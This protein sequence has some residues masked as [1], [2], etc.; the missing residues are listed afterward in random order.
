M[1]ID[2]QQIELLNKKAQQLNA[3]RQKLLGMQQSAREAF[4]KAVLLYKKKYGVD[5]DD[6][7]IQ[8]EY[9]RVLAKLKEDYENLKNKIIEIESGEYKK[10]VNTNNADL[11]GMLGNTGINL[12][13]LGQQSLEN[14]GQQ[15]QAQDLG[16]VGQQVQN[17]GIVGQQVQT[18][19][20]E[21]VQ[22][23]PGGNVQAPA[24][25][26]SIQGMEKLVASTN[27]GTVDV[28]K[29]VGVVFG[30]GVVGQDETSKVEN[31]ASDNESSEDPSE[32]PFTPE[33]WGKPKD[34]DTIFKN[35]IS[36]T[37]FE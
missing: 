28:E 9:Q 35:I 13:S 2:I 21:N 14:V 5:L 33:G 11:T 6:T 25:G 27:A 34:V 1:S 29:T 18:P 15:V 32:Q 23:S 4:E 17:L 3:E 7:N 36:G 16:N 30:Q 12:D 8:Q 37:K 22:S 20:V 19:V 10:K 26:L 24:G 31:T